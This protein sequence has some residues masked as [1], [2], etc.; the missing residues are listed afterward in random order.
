MLLWSSMVVSLCSLTTWSEPL[1]RSCWLGIGAAQSACRCLFRMAMAWRG[2]CTSLL[3]GPLAMSRCVAVFGQVAAVRTCGSANG[4]LDIRF[5]W[6]ALHRSR[7]SLV[8]ETMRKL[9][10]W[11]C[12][13]AP[14]RLGY[15]SLCKGTLKEPGRP[16]RKCIRLGTGKRFYIPEIGTHELGTH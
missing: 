8:R 14:M 15:N 3:Y 5:M 2:C 13:I 1:A 12:W 6:P 10:S 7:L 9:L 16:A 11:T 4:R